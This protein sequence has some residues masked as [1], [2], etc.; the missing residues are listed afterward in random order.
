MTKHPLLEHLRKQGYEVAQSVSTQVGESSMGPIHRNFL[1]PITD[2]SAEGVL[3][4]FLDEHAPSDLG[5][6]YLEEEVAMLEEA[7]RAIR[8]RIEG[9]YDH[10]ALLRAG[11]LG[12]KDA[13]ILRLIDPVLSD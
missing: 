11:A 5:V 6:S 13:D 8:A 1:A 10:P 9:E 7:L 3:R 12:D 2:A 4:G